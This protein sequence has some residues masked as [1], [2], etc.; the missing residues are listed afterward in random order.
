LAKLLKLR[1]FNSSILDNP[2]IG[3]GY[4]HG[5]RVAKLVTIESLI[6]HFT[7]TRT[8]TLILAA[9]IHDIGR[10]WANLADEHHGAKSIQV[11]CQILNIP[12]LNN[13]AI[14]ESL[15]GNSPIRFSED[16]VIILTN[17]VTNHSLS[18]PVKP[19]DLPIKPEL[20]PRESADESILEDCDALDRIRFRNNLNINY[21]RNDQSLCLLLLSYQLIQH[22]KTSTR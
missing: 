1:I 14:N 19:I 21:L 13:Q 9:F 11:L 17:I 7:A 15:F 4:N 5:Y 2:V 8:E 6:N 12:Q 18:I 16:D 22:T 3:H 10:N 20:I